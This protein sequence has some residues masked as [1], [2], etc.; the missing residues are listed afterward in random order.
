M[1][2]DVKGF[3][4]ICYIDLPGFTKRFGLKIGQKWDTETRRTYFV[5]PFP[6]VRSSGAILALFLLK[7][8]QKLFH[9]Q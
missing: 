3:F 2:V 9:R 4:T 1:L 7:V 6:I 8:F 5:R